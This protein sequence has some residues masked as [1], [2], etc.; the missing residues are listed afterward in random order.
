MATTS[1]TATA[2]APVSLIYTANRSPRG[3]A[4]SESF[5]Q[6]GISGRI[7]SPLSEVA[8]YPTKLST[9][10]FLTVTYIAGIIAALF[11]LIAKS[12]VSIKGGLGYSSIISYISPIKPIIPYPDLIVSFGKDNMKEAVE[13]K[14]QSLG[15]R[16]E[17]KG[18]RIF[19]RGPTTHENVLTILKMNPD[20]DTYAPFGA[21]NIMGYFSMKNLQTILLNVCAIVAETDDMEED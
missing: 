18:R 17:I 10:F 9:S 13:A 4:T 15:F 8:I 21:M 19:Y 16:K 6:H 12:S 14:M 7:A 5:P 2:S 1:T 3:Q 11:A 20:I